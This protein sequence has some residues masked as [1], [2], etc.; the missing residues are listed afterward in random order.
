MWASVSRLGISQSVGHQSVGWAS[1]IQLGIR[2]PTVS[3]ATLRRVA[4]ADIG[5]FRDVAALFISVRCVAADDGRCTAAVGRCT[6]DDGRC[7][8]AVGRCTADD[9]RF[10][11]LA[12][13]PATARRTVHCTAVRSGAAYFGRRRIADWGRWRCCVLPARVGGAEPGLSEAL[14][15]CGTG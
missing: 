12:C 2:R 1:V 15:F 14:L 11:L 6:A 8:A 7:T 10:G 4:E 9:G 3:G 13:L 5:R